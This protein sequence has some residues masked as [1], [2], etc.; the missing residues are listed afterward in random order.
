VTEEVVPTRFKDIEF[1]I[2]DWVV[3]TTTEFGP[4]ITEVRYGDLPNLLARLP[5]EIRIVRPGT[6]PYVFHGGHRL[7]AAPERASITY[8]PDAHECVVTLSDGVMTIVAPPDVAGL[9]KQMRISVDGAQL[10]IEH[11]LTNA[12]LDRIAAAAWAITQFGFGGTAILPFGRGVVEQEVQADRSLIL[13]PY[14]RLDDPRIELEPSALL[15]TA[16]PGPRLK[17][18]VGP[19]PG[20]LGYFVDET[21]F[22]KSVPP[23]YSGDFPDRGAVGQLFVDESFCELESLG[24]TSLLE[25]GDS[26]AT[27]ER[28]ELQLCADLET[29]VEIVTGGTP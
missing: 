22:L 29:A 11:R 28:W 21:L 12:A 10:S 16:S 18:G 2:G 5:P 3:S 20:L 17:F 13:W 1:Q 8:A 9:V 4:R 7:W 19:D 27:E 26:I 14:S 24:Q 23:G 15:V 6:D 25:P